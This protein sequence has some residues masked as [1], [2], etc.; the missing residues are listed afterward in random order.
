MTLIS[1]ALC[2]AM[3]PLCG[4]A[5]APVGSPDNSMG[6]R[7]GKIKPRA[8]NDAVEGRFG[9]GLRSGHKRNPRTEND[10]LSS[11]SGSGQNKR[12][13][14]RPK[15]K[16]PEESLGEVLGSSRISHSRRSRL[17]RTDNPWLAMQAAREAREAAS[18]D[19]AASLGSHV[20][21]LEVAVWVNEA[22]RA[23][24]GPDGGFAFDETAAAAGR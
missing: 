13:R 19:G 9:E 12:S 22:Q 4:S 11:S 10:G 2:A 21:P 8:G 17:G 1:S 23:A 7:S 5:D 24:C 16:I 6:I 20:S 15:G 14:A 18:Q 3:L